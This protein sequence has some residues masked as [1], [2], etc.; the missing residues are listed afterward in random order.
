MRYFLNHRDIRRKFK[1]DLVYQKK[2]SIIKDL[3]MAVYRYHDGIHRNKAD[4]IMTGLLR[5]LNWEAYEVKGLPAYSILYIPEMTMDEIILHIKACLNIRHLRFAG[6]QNTICK[7]IGIFVGYRGSGEL[8]IPLVH[9][10]NLDLLIYGEG[11]EWEIP[12][13]IRDAF[14]QGR[15]KAVIVLGHAES[16]APGMRY[17]AESIQKQFP[18]IPVHFMS[19][20]SVFQII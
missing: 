17:L 20:K 18:D 14:A 7:R 9:E 10:E 19:E 16:E 1:K 5:Q 15:Q 3:N 12:E 6:D 13:Y 8:A 11:P 2:V 4:G